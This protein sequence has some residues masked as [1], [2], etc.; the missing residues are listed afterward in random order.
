MQRL[1]RSGIK[2][3]KHIFNSEASEDL[4]T[5]I[6]QHGIEYQKVL[7]NM[8]S[9]NAAEKAISTFKDYFKAILTGVDK[10][11]WMHLWDRL[12]PQAESTHNMLWPT[13]I[14]PKISAYAYMYVQHY[15]NK[16]PLAPMDCAVLL[17]N[18]PKT[19]RI[20][21]NHVIKGHY[22]KTL[23]EHYWCYKIWIKNTRSI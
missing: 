20:L 5:A 23:R 9:R 15:F 10:T 21:D 8:H 1:N 16:M 7:P 17:H 6:R 2:I 4:L 13:N 14:A 12:L 11:F 18:K 19:R 22:I 3:K